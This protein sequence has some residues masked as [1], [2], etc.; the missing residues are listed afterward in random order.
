[1]QAAEADSERGPTMSPPNKNRRV[2]QREGERRKDAAHAL[3]ET[4]RDVY[5][6]RARRALLLRLLEVGTATA[7][8]VAERIGQAPEASTADFSAQCRDRLPEPGSSGEQ[9]SPRQHGRPV[10]H[11]SCRS[12]HSTTGPGRLPGSP[13]ILN[14]PNPSQATTPGR[15]ARRPR[16]RRAR[17]PSPLRCIKQ[18]S[19]DREAHRCQPMGSPFKDSKHG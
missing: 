8:D 4:H 15:Q 9:A 1:M 7:D 10:T 17:H 14:C 2:E 19:S 11:Q 18:A 12:G 13:A 5:I 6:R 3:L 16:S